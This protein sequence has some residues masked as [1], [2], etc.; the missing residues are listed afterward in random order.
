MQLRIFLNMRSA[1]KPWVTA[2]AVLVG[3]LPLAVHA[4]LD[5]LNWTFRVNGQ[6][7][8]VNDDGTLMIP[9]I[10][11]PDLFGPGGPG[12]VPDFISDDFVRVIGFSDNTGGV[13]LYAFSE[14]FRIVQG[15]N[16][17]ITNWTFT[18]VPP[19]MPE[20]IHARPEVS[21]I[22]NL[23][24]RPRVL[25]TGVLADGSEVDVTGAENWTSYR[26]SNIELAEIDGNGLITPKSPGVVFVAAVNEGS[27]SVAQVD[28]ALGDVLTT[29]EGFVQYPDG[30]PAAGATVEFPGLASSGT[31]GADGR[32]SVG[33]VPTIFGQIGVLVRA[34]RSGQGYFGFAVQLNPEQGAITD[35]GIIT[36]EAPSSDQNIWLFASGD[37]GDS[38][39]WSQG[40]TPDA[41]DSVVIPAFRSD[42]VIRVAGADFTVRGLEVDAELEIA[43]NASLN[44]TGSAVISGRLAM[45]PGSTMTASGPSA[46]VEAQ[47][48]TSIDGG[49]LLAVNGGR[50]RLPNLIHYRHGSTGNSQTRTFRAEGFGSE[51]E[52]SALE[53]ILNG[54]HYGSVL[55]IQGLTGGRVSATNLLQI[56]EN[57]SG[58]T[59]LRSVQLSADGFGS[60]LEFPALTLFEDVNADVRSVLLVRNGGE[61]QAPSLLTMQ[62]ID[63]SLDGLG[64]FTGG[65]ILEFTSGRLVM[66]RLTANFSSLQDATGTTIE[67]EGTSVTLD[68]LERIDGASL[69]VRLGG[70]LALPSVRSYFVNAQGNNEVRRFRADGAGSRLSL[71]NLVGIRNGDAFGSDFVVES[72]AG[73]QIDLPSLVQIA[74]VG[75]DTRSRQVRVTADGFGSAVDVRNLV[76]FFDLDTDDFSTINAVN[77]G[78]VRLGKLRELR[79]VNLSLS[80]LSS[81]D[82]STLQRIRFTTLTADGVSPN[83]GALVDVEGSSIQVRS[84][85]LE[86]PNVVRA[87]GA[88]F[89]ALL[90][91]RLTLPA[92]VVYSHASTA[93]SQTRAFRAEGTGSELNLPALRSLL[94]GSHY[95]SRVRVDAVAG[96]QVNVSA[97]EQIVDDHEGDARERQVLVHADGL[98][99]RVN[100]AGLRNF[101]DVDGGRPS[102]LTVANG[103]AL[104]LNEEQLLLVNVTRTAGA[105]T[106]LAQE[107]V[108]PAPPILGGESAA[109]DP[110]DGLDR[111]LGSLGRLIAL[112]SEGPPVFDANEIRWIGEQDGAW[113]SPTNWSVGRVPGPGDNVVIN[114]PNASVVV[115]VSGIDARV[116]GLFCTEALV[117]ASGSLTVHGQADLEGP[118]TM[119]PGATLIASGE[120]A[121]LLASGSATVNGGNF[122]ALKGGQIDLPTVFTYA[123]AS[124]GN[125]QTRTFLAIETGSRIEFAGMTQLRN[126]THYDSDLWFQALAGGTISMPQLRDLVDPAGGD[127]RR[128]QII[129]DARGQGSAILLPMVQRF[130][131]WN[132]EQYSWI[133]A[134]DGASVE[135]AQLREATGIQVIFNGTGSVP[136][137]GLTY[138]WDSRLDLSGGDVALPN[139][140]EALRTVFQVNGVTLTTPALTTLDG[141][142]LVTVQGGVIAM[143]GVRSYRFAST[144]NSQ[145][146]VFRS[147]GAGSRIALPGV[148]ELIGGEHYNSEMWVEALMGGEIALPAMVE[149]REA[150]SGDYRLGGV[151]FRA[152]G[153]GSRL[154]LTQL[155]ALRDLGSDRLSLLQAIGGG[156]VVAG[157]LRSAKGVRL[158]FSGMGNLAPTNLVELID[159]HLQVVG[160]PVSF[161]MLEN[162]MRTVFEVDGVAVSFPAIRYADGAQFRATGGGRMTFPA[163]AQYAHAST[164]NHLVRGFIARE[165][166]SLL[167]FPVLR[168]LVNGVHHN[169]DLALMA[170]AGG[171]IELPML[172]QMV[173]P[174]EGDGARRQFLVQVN[175]YQSVIHAPEWA[176]LRDRSAD[177]RSLIRAVNRGL[178]EAESLAYLDAVDLNVNPASGA[179]LMN[180]AQFRN[181]LWVITAGDPVLSETMSDVRGSTFVVEGHTLAI[182]NVARIDGASF[183]VRGGGLLSLPGVFHYSHD[184]TGNNQAR[185][186]RAEGA[187]SRIEMVNLRSIIN[188]SHYDSDVRVEAIDGGRVDLREL[189]QVIE[190]DGGDVRFRQF[191]VTSSGLNSSVDLRG[192]A[193]LHDVSADQPSI[194]MEADGG[195]IFA[196]ALEHLVGVD[197]T[198]ASTNLTLV[199]AREIHNSRITLRGG[200]VELPNLIRARR[201]TVVV[202]GVPMTLGGLVDADGTSFLISGGGRLVLPALSVYAHESLNNGE[203]RTFRAEGQGSRLE[204]PS[205]LSLINGTHNNSDIRILANAG[206]VVD[207]SSLGQIVEATTGDNRQRDV[208]V[209]ATGTNS[210]V[211]LTGLRHF[212]DANPDSRSFLAVAEGGQIVVDTETL[213]SENV[214]FDTLAGS[215]RFLASVESEA[216]S[217]ADRPVPGAPM[218]E[219][220]GV[221]GWVAVTDMAEVRGFLLAAVDPLP[222]ATLRWIGGSGNWTNTAN[223]DLGRVPRANDFV[224]IAAAQGPITVT[225]SSGSQ[226]VGG[227]NCSEDLVIAGGS[228]T[229]RGLGRITGVL[230]MGLGTSLVADGAG[231]DVT[232][233]GAAVLN[234]ANFYALYG[235]RLELSGLAAYEHGSTGNNQNRVFLAFGQGSRLRFPA[236]T[237]LANGTNYDSDLRIEAVGGG[238]IDMPLLTQITDPGT[239]DTRLRQVVLQAD[240]TGSQVLVPRLATWTDRNADER[241]LLRAVN[242]GTVATPALRE[243]TGTEVALDGTGVINVGVLANLTEGAITLYRDAQVAFPA[244]VNASGTR[245]W[246]QQ[247][248]L[249][250]GEVQNFDAG[251][252]FAV[253]GGLVTLSK[254]LTYSHL[255]TANS[256]RRTFR[257]VGWGSRVSL[258]EL[259]SVTSGSHYDSDILID[260]MEGGRIFLPK[261]LQMVE[262]EAG[263]TRQRA[264]V[265]RAFGQES[266]VDLTAMVNFQD[267]NADEFSRL[268]ARQGGSIV[269]PALRDLRGVHLVVDRGSSVLTGEF[270]NFVNGRIETQGAALNLPKLVT[271][272]GTEWLVDQAEVTMTTIASVNG[273]SFRVSGGGRLSFPAV[274]SYLHASTANSQRRTFVAIEDGSRLEFPALKSL[275]NGE[276]YDSDV[277]LEAL[278]G[279]RIHMSQLVQVVDPTAGDTRQRQVTV[280]AAGVGSEIDLTSMANLLDQNSDILSSFSARW[281]GRLIT[282]AMQSLQAVDLLLTPDGSIGL[283]ALRDMTSGSLRVV[284]YGSTQ[285]LGAL[286]NAGRTTITVEGGVVN[287][288]EMVTFDGGNVFGSGGAKAAFPKVLTYSHAST[289]N[290]QARRFSAIEAGT[291]LVFAGLQS[292]SN[293]THYD[294][295]LIIEALVGGRVDLRSVIQIFDPSDGDT[296]QREVRVS[297]DGFNSQV[298]LTSLASFVDA[299]PDV[300]SRIRETNGGEVDYPAGASLVNVT[301]E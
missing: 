218:S 240:G 195:T 187:G 301:V 80:G 169:S 233:T 209:L 272:T 140:V 34:Q 67:V 150:P 238:V 41:Q 288:P 81:L 23:T 176:T 244:L 294:S 36:L 183:T 138:L 100:L 174:D 18:A 290:G 274:A 180:V 106:Q 127:V 89:S 47:G 1:I 137:T 165:T 102:T 154:D 179:T 190:S 98:G 282:P 15:A 246:V 203:T 197:L 115:T 3:L 251:S 84:T 99:S 260:A 126:G 201:N 173:D 20:A 286:V 250:L 76:N 163:L 229:V 171:R 264:M 71:T 40:S 193:Y 86:L 142:E 248:S 122:I 104:T 45:L 29:V 83:L 206:G 37:W 116:R 160:V 292:I 259:R 117:V 215:A 35:A 234:G 153:V 287:F 101:I 293:G 175:G 230:S 151:Y 181:S 191:V 283:G 185:V 243:A 281:G 53:T 120:E 5:G 46:V 225:I 26:I 27:T 107:T 184:S 49:N 269:S 21:T 8:N 289:G 204:M 223:W 186:F 64:T 205:L 263:D 235:G 90:A 87:N 63:M 30:S 300:A 237:V 188:G 291:E 162:A 69:L 202:E 60:T 92:L 254:V 114:N 164:E 182:T 166:G 236:L 75:G 96:G 113:S 31:T 38:S 220:E 11:A 51:L 285:S 280:Y 247:T 267:L 155:Q 119:N 121:R 161:P 278:V 22:T 196:S 33:N 7:V 299:N 271:A 266:L 95:Q 128:R 226:R 189:K 199:A 249:T 145:Q 13:P 268:E 62:G 70:S 200:P 109:S 245:I 48:P 68:G 58:D 143:D 39:R 131:Q 123:H 239:G 16:Y 258:P 227:L 284:G 139:L 256:Q 74:E 270:F 255:S 105:S 298:V 103:G 297:A 172:E 147:V 136:L 157:Q 54:S 216:E 262:P 296:R 111:D 242:G 61:V 224:E 130:H 213:I 241:S 44:V 6:A 279:G 214:D 295:D 43:G 12:T 159:G 158:S 19:I 72:L 219:E 79:G 52:L 14:W 59:R 66:N 110:L 32:F 17:R 56:V 168:D 10:S 212:R 73:G 93:N 192:L 232:V 149:T 211:D 146:R 124:T 85:V 50:I 42:S 208:G 125:S 144:G 82:L 273:G 132:N 148:R 231:A 135:A 207:L 275:V 261:V 25:V 141:S 156:E 108:L 228:L 91:G 88:N 210:V 55:R 129:L 217:E 78:E 221:T 198:L 2:L 77:G 177:E 97:L 194:L 152:D 133:R 57:T 178:L 24:Q 134:L 28:I 277:S 276:H 112:A 253:N 9:N 94:N 65:Q 118:L 265:V 167:S 252:I 4:Q 170:F 257:A 222:P